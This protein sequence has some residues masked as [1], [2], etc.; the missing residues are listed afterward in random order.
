MQLILWS[1]LEGA[2]RI[3]KAAPRLSTES[4]DS[5][6]RLSV[7]NKRLALLHQAFGNG[8]PCIGGFVDHR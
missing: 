1:K 7:G 8:D 2:A 4:L 5:V 6:N 3:L